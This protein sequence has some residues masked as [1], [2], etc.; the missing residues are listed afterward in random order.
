MMGQF[1]MQ[2]INIRLINQASEAAGTEV[3]FNGY[4]R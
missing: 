1:I 3:L 2:F 4:T